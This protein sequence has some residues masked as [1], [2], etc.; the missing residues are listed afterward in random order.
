[1]LRIKK[2]VAEGNRAT[3]GNGCRKSSARE[4]GRENRG[5]GE[6]SDKR[7]VAPTEGTFDRANRTPGAFVTS[8]LEDQE[9]PGEF[10]VAF[11]GKLSNESLERQRN[12]ECCPVT[13]ERYAKTL[14]G[15]RDFS[16]RSLVKRSLGS[17]ASRTFARSSSGD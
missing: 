16:P 5:D 11:D 6:R 8:Q 1:M 9:V 7:S 10:L 13:S 15:D 3:E 2:T 12:H 14:N 17:G 4:K